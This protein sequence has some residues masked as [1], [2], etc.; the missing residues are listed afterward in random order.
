MVTDDGVLCI[1]LKRK[2]KKEKRPKFTKTNN[3]GFVCERQRWVG[4][5]E[6]KSFS[7]VNATRYSFI[8][9]LSSSTTNFVYTRFLLVLNINIE[10]TVDIEYR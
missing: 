8:H 9:S 7:F 10:Y 3:I 4:S 6:N 5:S 2:R 1:L